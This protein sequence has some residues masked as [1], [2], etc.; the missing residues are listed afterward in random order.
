MR[1]GEYTKETRMHFLYLSDV[2]CPWCYG[3]GPVLRRIL[4]DHPD[5]PGRVLGG[6][7]V[8]DPRMLSDMK[9]GHPAIRDFFTRLGTSTGQPVDAFV[10]ALD[11]AGAGGPDW[12]MYSPEANVP[13]V[14]LKTLAPGHEVEQMEAFQHL[15]YGEGRNPLDPAARHAILARWGVDADAFAAVCARP[16]VLARAERE[17]AE[18][19]EIMG[20]FYI[21][22]T[23]YLE[24]DGARELLA[25]GYAPYE[26]VRATVDAALA[27]TNQT[28][29]E[30]AACGLDGK[31]R[32]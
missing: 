7:L 15:V 1:T 6:D 28:V 9:K 23:L 10:R 4:A 5:V 18:A 20:E 32:M 16:D 2:F 19:L 29:A 17:T 14:A 3:F 31:C 11:C 8:D 30:G 26:T 27:G 13:L 21:Y 24:R 22:P 25:R 12:R